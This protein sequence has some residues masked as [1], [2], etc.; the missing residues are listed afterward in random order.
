MSRREESEVGV[1]NPQLLHGEVTSALQD[2]SHQSLGH[3]SL[4]L[5]SQA[6]GE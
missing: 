2:S 4:P 3:L 1:F 6:L 5:A